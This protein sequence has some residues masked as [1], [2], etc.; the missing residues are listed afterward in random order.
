MTFEHRLGPEE[1]VLDAAS[2]WMMCSDQKQKHYDGSM[3]GGRCSW[4]AD[5][6][7]IGL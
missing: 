6:R 5:T 7:G 4:E 3:T 1:R 2:L